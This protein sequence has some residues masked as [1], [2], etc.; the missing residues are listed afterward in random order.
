MFNIHKSRQ[1]IHINRNYDDL[2]NGKM[3]KKANLTVEEDKQS[4][5]NIKFSHFWIILLI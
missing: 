4:C 1:I 2:Q 5:G 3:L